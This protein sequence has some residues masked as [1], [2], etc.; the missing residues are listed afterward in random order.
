MDNKIV[1]TTYVPLQPPFQ[2]IKYGKDVGMQ[3]GTLIATSQLKG[4]K[5]QPFKVE[6]HSYPVVTYG[7]KERAPKDKHLFG[8]VFMEGVVWNRVE[9]RDVSTI[10]LSDSHLEWQEF[11]DS[12]WEDIARTS[13]RA[14]PHI[15]SLRDLLDLGVDIA[16]LPPTKHILHIQSYCDDNS[17]YMLRTSRDDILALNTVYFPCIEEMADKLLSQVWKYEMIMILSGNYK[18]RWELEYTTDE[19]YL[20]PIVDEMNKRSKRKFGVTPDGALGLISDDESKEE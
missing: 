1:S 12:L 4:D 8:K 2:I 14:D 13:Q 17:G 7:S 5:D 10:C 3:I 6:T 11:V 16:P 15:D 20:Q 18:K 19:E 9:L